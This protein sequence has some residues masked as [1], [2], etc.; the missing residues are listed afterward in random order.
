MSLMYQA[1]SVVV[2]AT[3]WGSIIG[4][5]G[6]AGNGIVGLCDKTKFPCKEMFASLGLLAGSLVGSSHAQSYV[7]A[8]TDP[9]TGQELKAPVIVAPDFIQAS[10][11]SAKPS[12]RALG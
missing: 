6:F 7:K 2:K 11:S 5:I 4:G 8:H 1:A 9:V 10:R 3:E 12:G